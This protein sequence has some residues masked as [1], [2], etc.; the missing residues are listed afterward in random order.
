MS[1][2]SGGTRLG[3][4]LWS[5]ATDWAAFEAAARRVDDLG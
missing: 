2:D 1:A 5:Q 3:I 4:L